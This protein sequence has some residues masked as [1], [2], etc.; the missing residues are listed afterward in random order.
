MPKFDFWYVIGWLGIILNAAAMFTQAG[1]FGVVCGIIW[2][3]VWGAL[4]YFDWQNRR[5]ERIEAEYF[6]L[7][8]ETRLVD[9]ILLGRTALSPEEAGEA[10]RSMF[11]PS[12]PK[13]EE[14]TDCKY[15]ANSPHLLCTVNPCGLCEGCKDYEPGNTNRK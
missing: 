4:A 3:S 2:C 1:V 9:G 11:K 8:Q 14:K 7:I 10:L 12:R 13:S 5:R 15:H 6:R